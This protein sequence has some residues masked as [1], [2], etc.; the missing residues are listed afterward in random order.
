MLNPAMGLQTASRWSLSER[1]VP[2][3][4]AGRSCARGLGPV[5]I[6]IPMLAHPEEM[7]QVRQ[8]LLRAE[9]QLDAGASLGLGQL[10]R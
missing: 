7:R 8:M 2:Q 4:A 1:H 9:R 3:A 6:L 5:Q 10:G